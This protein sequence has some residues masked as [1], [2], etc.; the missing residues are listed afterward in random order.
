[1]AEDR[2]SDNQVF[3]MEEAVA[4]QSQFI[5]D[6]LDLAGVDAIISLDEIEASILAK[7][8]QYCKFDADAQKAKQL[9]GHDMEKWEKDFVDVD[10]DTITL[11]SKVLSHF[12]L[13]SWSLDLNS[14]LFVSNEQFS[15]LCKLLITLA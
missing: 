11:L 8:Y 15:V 7:V 9:W 6:A 14:L 4:F 12:S 13:W 2:S 1:M 3:E 10:H 5:K